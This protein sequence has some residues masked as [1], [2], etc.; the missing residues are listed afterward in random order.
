MRIKELTFRDRSWKT[1]CVLQLDHSTGAKYSHFIARALIN[2][3]EDLHR[4]SA[5]K[6]L[7]KH[8]VDVVRL[9]RSS[10]GKQITSKNEQLSQ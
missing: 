10:F 8:R 2:F 5:V 1:H 3:S 4:G 9:P 7:V 6:L